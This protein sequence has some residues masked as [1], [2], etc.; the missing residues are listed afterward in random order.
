MS[1]IAQLLAELGGLGPAAIPDIEYELAWAQR[2]TAYTARGQIPW[3]RH[4]PWLRNR[5]S[6][7]Q[8]HQC[9]WCRK[10]MIEA[11]PLDDRPTLEHI[12]PLSEGGEDT[13]ANLA[14]AC[15]RCNN[16]RG[17]GDLPT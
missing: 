5:L 4:F 11:G 14:V 7:A 8:G 13:P 2:S 1:S 3:S 6:E 15:F 10:R 17:N 16:R 12:V 9:C